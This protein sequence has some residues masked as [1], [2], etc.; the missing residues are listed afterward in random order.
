MPQQG[1]HILSLVLSLVL[2]LS[3]SL[4]PS[5]FLA[6]EMVQVQDD[7]SISPKYFLSSLG[8]LKTQQKASWL[9]GS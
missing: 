2:S 4:F 5:L 7:V 6:L 8:K 9:I 1:Q 3:L